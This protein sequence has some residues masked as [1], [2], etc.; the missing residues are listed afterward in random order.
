MC[1]DVPLNH[2]KIK[3][4]IM[5]DESPECE[6]Y[7]CNLFALIIMNLNAL[8]YA[9]DNFFISYNVLDIWYELY[10]KNMEKVFFSDKTF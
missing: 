2:I 6:V 1:A 5:R 4:K 7:H 3:I 10:I 8:L 9:I